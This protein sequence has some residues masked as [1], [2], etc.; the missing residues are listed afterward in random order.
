[1]P[2]ALIKY[3]HRKIVEHYKKLA[4]ESQIVWIRENLQRL[5]DGEGVWS[6]IMGKPRVYSSPAINLGDIYYLDC[7]QF[8]CQAPRIRIGVSIA[9]FSKHYLKRGQYQ[10]FIVKR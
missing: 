1:M 7:Y 3:E 8:M 2:N 6:G 5:R 10:P 4:D 9:F